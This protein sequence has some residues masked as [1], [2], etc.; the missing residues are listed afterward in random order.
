M[1][2]YQSFIDGKWLDSSNGKVIAVDNPATGE[3]IGEVA[4]ASNQDVDMAVEAAKNSFKKM[5]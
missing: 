2:K 1:K 4:C 3:I 5:I